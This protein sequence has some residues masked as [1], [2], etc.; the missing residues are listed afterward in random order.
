VL[1]EHTFPN[2]EGH[3]RQNELILEEVVEAITSLPKGKAPSH[4]GLPTEF[5]QENVE[6]TAPTFLLAFR[7]ML[8]L[9]LTSD[10]INERMITLISKFVDHSKLGKLATYHS[11]WRY[12]QNTRQNP[13][14]KDPGSSTLC[15]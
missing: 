7:T 5:F 9:G 15:D 10:F 2:H 11:S 3:E 13:S 14:A 8:S 4:D 6:E 12:L 1:G